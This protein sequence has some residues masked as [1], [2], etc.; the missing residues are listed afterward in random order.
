[1]VINCTKRDGQV[2]PT[3]RAGEECCPMKEEAGTCCEKAFI[4]N[5]L[6]KIELQGP[7]MSLEHDA[8]WKEGSGAECWRGQCPL[9]AWGWSRGPHARTP[10]PLA[11]SCHQLGTL[12]MENILTQRAGPAGPSR[13]A[14]V[15]APSP[16]AEQLWLLSALSLSIGATT[17]TAPGRV[18]LG[19]GHLQEWRPHLCWAAGAV[20]LTA[21]Q[22][23]FPYATLRDM[24]QNTGEEVVAGRAHP[25]LCRTAPGTANSIP[26]VLSEGLC[27]TMEA[28]RLCSRAKRDRGVL[29]GL[30]LA[31]QI[32]A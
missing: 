6:K 30:G 25:G 2:A 5:N 21:Q 23:V 7:E 12:L 10:P 24:P 16:G 32:T 27:Q 26:R 28:R 14:L 15:A 17:P 9:P 8:G 20:L 18:P 22:E 19:V 1:M 31:A 3:P 29:L 11:W 13:C 4:L